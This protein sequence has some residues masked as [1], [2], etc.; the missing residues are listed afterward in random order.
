MRPER[1][2]RGRNEQ[3]GF[4]PARPFWRNCDKSRGGRGRAPELEIAKPLHLTSPALFS[5]SAGGT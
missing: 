4:V 5:N 3:G 1:R 2:L